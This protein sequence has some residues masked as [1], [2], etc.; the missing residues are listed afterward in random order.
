[1]PRR[2]LR[3]SRVIGRSEAS[4]E[5][6]LTRELGNLAAKK[7]PQNA[8]DAAQLTEGPIKNYAARSLELDINQTW[9]VDEFLRATLYQQ[10]IG[11]QEPFQDYDT[12]EGEHVRIAITRTEIIKHG[13]D[14]AGDTSN[15]HYHPRKNP[16]K[17]VSLEQ[18]AIAIVEGRIR[19]DSWTGP[20][21]EHGSVENCDEYEDRPEPL[22]E[23]IE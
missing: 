19:S 5:F 20:V 9:I 11:Q 3:P 6:E 23:K 15:G 21:P 12:E 22:V 13:A 10:P 1:M 8:N 17:Q 2:R 14:G 4:V 16:P 18:R 7:H